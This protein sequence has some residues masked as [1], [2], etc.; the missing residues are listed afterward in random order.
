MTERPLFYIALVAMIIGSQLFLA[1]F[2][3]ELISRNN[4]ERNN[5]FIL[6]NDTFY[7][8]DNKAEMFTVLVDQGEKLKKYIHSNKVD[9]KDDYESA[10][11]RCVI[12]YAGLKR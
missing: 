10:L 12:Y 1:G 7:K 9:F 5:Y 2:L 11:L 4:V 8:S 6:Y 3:G